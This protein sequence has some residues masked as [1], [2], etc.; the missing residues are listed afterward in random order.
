LSRMATFSSE[1]S[2]ERTAPVGDGVELI[3][4]AKR[5]PRFGPVTLV[6]MGGLYAELLGDVAV[7][8]APADESET[9]RLIGSLRGAPLLTGARGRPALD[10]A[11]AAR[12]TAAISRLA[13]EHPEV[14]EVEVNPLLLLPQGALG[15]DARI[16]LGSEIERHAG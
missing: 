7:A 1:Y 3:V 12:A 2:V 10:V 11:A 9:E 15:L 16:V 13:A 8:L 4:G 5:D 6:G 14:E